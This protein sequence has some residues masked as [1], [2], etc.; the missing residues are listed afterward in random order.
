VCQAV[1]S[2]STGAPR[3]RTSPPPGGRLPAL[4]TSLA[5]SAAV[6]RSAPASK[7][8]E[9]RGAVPQSVQRDGRQPG[10]GDQ[11]PEQAGHPVRP[12]R[13]PR[14]GRERVP[15]LCPPGPGG[16]PLGL[17][18]QP[19]LAQRR[20]RCLVQRPRARS[21]ARG[22]RGGG[23]GAGCRAGRTTAG[24]I[25]LSSRGPASRATLRATGTRPAWAPAA[26][27]AAGRSTSSPCCRQGRAVTSASPPGRRSTAQPDKI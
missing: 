1:I 10:G 11:L 25:S 21:G 19:V 22:V 4:R 9:S 3:L 20:D 7:L 24:A 15:G 2:T 18:P 17:L 13:L 26:M 8:V 23:R 12:D 16:G 14:P 6:F 27:T 5:A